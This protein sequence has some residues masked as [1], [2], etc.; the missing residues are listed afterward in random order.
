[1]TTPQSDRIANVVVVVAFLNAVLW[2][3]LDFAFAICFLT[4][5]FSFGV[6]SVVAIAS[7]FLFSLAFTPYSW[8]TYWFSLAPL[9]CLWHDKSTPTTA[10]RCCVEA[11]VIGF[12]V[13][14]LVSSFF[15]TTVTMWSVLIR[16]AAC[17]AYS[18]QFIAIAYVTHSWRQIS[19]SMAAIPISVVATIAEVIQAWIGLTWAVTNP[20]LA[21]TLVILVFALLLHKGLLHDF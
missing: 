1:M 5:V 6:R 4:I 20:I 10:F 11:I 15:H 13:C 19:I 21:I 18:W 8:P 9:I 7:V 3:R 16:G 17:L 12:S 2:S 14:W